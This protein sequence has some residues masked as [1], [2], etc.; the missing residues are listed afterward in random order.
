[1][2]THGRD[3]EI[4]GALHRIQT[5]LQPVC[6]AGVIA[7]HAIDVLETTLGYEFGALLLVDEST[8]RL[9]PIA[10]SDQGRGEEFREADARYIESR[11]V[12]RG[13]GITGWVART[14]KSVLTGNA[15]HDRR[16]FGIRDHIRSEVCVP[17]RLEGH[18]LGVLNVETP[19]P[20]AYGET[21]VRVLEMVAG[22]IST[23]IDSDRL[24]ESLCRSQRI[25]LVG[26]LAGGMAHDLNKLLTAVLANS[27]L[28]KADLAGDD[29]LM[30]R[31]CEI[32]DVTDRMS[33]MTRQLL[34][35]I[36]NKPSR[37]EEL[38]L[39]Q[40]IGEMQPLLRS[41]AGKGVDLTCRFRAKHDRIFADRTQLGQVVMNLVV[42]A[43]QAMPEGGRLVVE[44]FDCSGKHQSR[45]H[46]AFSVKDTGHGMDAETRRNAFRAFY[47]TKLDG[48]GLGLATVHRIVGDL[49]GRIGVRS[50][51][52]KGT[53]FWIFL[54][55][56][57][58]PVTAGLSRGQ[59][60]DSHLLL[61]SV[62]PKTGD[63]P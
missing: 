62:F 27:E 37:L 8:D 1:M 60:G 38:G 45:D 10:L 3:L 19:R 6:R 21:D 63:C 30:T 7:Q 49:G 57:T 56:V 20:H 26:Q 33:R 39:N 2:T 28:L 55:T 59:T 47:T 23:A 42:N 17:I 46:V 5:A 16:Y 44:T 12:R 54:P 52:E 43:R 36:R 41:L 51:R 48:T 34:G 53:T 4:L 15:P 58:N 29:S 61:D 14:G 22:R 24:R 40:V 32:A 50:A 18:T 11:D 13:R 35:F 9:L 31:V 25:E